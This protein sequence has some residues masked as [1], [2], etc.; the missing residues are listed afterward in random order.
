M[1][2]PENP[3]PA[4]EIIQPTAPTEQQSVTE[5]PEQTLSTVVE[6]FSQNR[7]PT[8]A[9]IQQLRDTVEQLRSQGDNAQIQENLSKLLEATERNAQVTEIRELQRS[10]IRLRVA[11]QLA[12]LHES[13]RPYVQSVVSTTN[14]VTQEYPGVT[15]GVGL[16]GAAILTYA[17]MRS[18]GGVFGWIKSGVFATLA[19][20]TGTFGLSALADKFRQGTN[21]PDEKVT[22]ETEA[23][24]KKLA[25]E[26]L[27]GS[28]TGAID[29]NNQRLTAMPPATAPD[30]V[31]LSRYAPIQVGQQRMQLERFNN[32]LV[33]RVGTRR[34]RAN[35]TIEI[36]PTIPGTS[37]TI[38]FFAASRATLDI[39]EILSR[40]QVALIGGRNLIRLDANFSQARTVTGD[41][42]ARGA[43][44]ALGGLGAQSAF[45]APGDLESALGTLAGGNGPHSIAVRHYERRIP[46]IG[47]TVAFTLPD[48]TAFTEMTRQITFTSVA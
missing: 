20:V 48:G 22:K 19:A 34:F 32:G 26:L 42:L 2:V 29:I 38:P 36:T 25:E 6:G 21:E 41:L 14:F 23:A 10:L 4:P 1:P 16:S 18:A 45:I 39:G 12:Y 37:I 5:S 8:K 31:G 7:L 46:G 27:K 28:T 30:L 33:I 3:R 35:T 11:P 9:Q 47:G 44:T 13:I 15:A 43:I 24:T 17:A 40:G